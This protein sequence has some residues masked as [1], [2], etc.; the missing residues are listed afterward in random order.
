MECAPT[1]FFFVGMKIFVGA[2]FVRPISPKSIYIN[3][4]EVSHRK[5]AI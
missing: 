1:A 3:I 5:T 2:S 4:F